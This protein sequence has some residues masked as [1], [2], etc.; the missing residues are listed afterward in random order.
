MPR[1]SLI[2]VVILFLGLA[3]PG[4]GPLTG[5]ESDGQET[6]A[7]KQDQPGPPAPSDLSHVTCATPAPRG[8]TVAPAPPAYSGGQ[9]P[10]LQPGANTLSSG[11]VVRELV[12]VVP[13]N[14]RA[15]ERLP[16]IFLWHWLGGKASKMISKA[17]V[18][19]AVDQQRFIAVVPE[20]QGDLT[21]RWPLMPLGGRDRLEQELTFFDDMLACVSAQF[22]VNRDCVSSFGI[23]AGA[24]FTTTLASARSEYLSSFTVLSGGS[25]A[26][27]GSGWLNLNRLLWSWTPAA[28]KL[29]ALVLWGGPEDRCVMTDFDYASRTLKRGL[30]D[31][32]HF[33][34]ECVHNCGHS[35]P[36]LEPPPGMSR[37]ASL[38]QFALSH[39]YW[40]PPG[41][42]PLSSAR[43]PGLPSWCAA[44]G[45]ATMREGQCAPPDC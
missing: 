28:R 2:L 7:G 32:G 34:V 33:T 19:A 4:C 35:F 6:W 18:Q 39:P 26:P 40:L 1:G 31:G 13:S 20:D 36:P 5:A 23:S 21:F 38:W 27:G 17:E 42:S 24:I 15:E 45:D 10:L 12:L 25:G 30:R 44:D 3:L 29:P 37:F 41:Q 11:G 9:C 14:L 8:A 43:P 16:V 22:Y